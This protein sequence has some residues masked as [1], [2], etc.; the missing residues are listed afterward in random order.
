MYSQALEQQQQQQQ[1]PAGALTVRLLNTRAEAFIRQERWELALADTKAALGLCH[2]QPHRL[3][4]PALAKCHFRHAL[5]LLSLQRPTVALAALDEACTAGDKEAATLR[6]DAARAL[7]EQRDGKHDLLA[8]TEEAKRAAAAQRRGSSS[9]SGAAS[10]S[11][12]HADFQSP[13]AHVVLGTAKGRSVV[14]GAPLQGGTLVMAAKAFAFVRGSDADHLLSF[15]GTSD[16]C[17]EGSNARMLV[18]VVHA[19]LQC[20]ERGPELYSLSVWGGYDAGMPPGR[21]AWRRRAVLT[22][23]ASPPS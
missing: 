15:D 16:R 21:S 20:P 3:Q 14:A 10:L 18:H 7:E 5:E 4:I 6:R 17:D 22:C 23:H 19:L 1:D 9:S 8:M 2:T 11:R 13:H 12:R